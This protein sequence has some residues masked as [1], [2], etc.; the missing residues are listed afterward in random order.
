MLLFNGLFFSIL[1]GYSQNTSSQATASIAIGASYGHALS[2]TFNSYDASGNFYSFYGDATIND[3][4]VGRAQ[5]SQLIP[6]SLSNGLDDRVDSGWSINGSLGYNV[7]TASLPALHIPIMATMGYASFKRSDSFTEPGM[8][9]G[10]TIAP[11][12]FLNDKFIFN[13]SLRWLKG[14]EVDNG[15]EIGQT[16]ISIGVMIRIL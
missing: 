13:A 4:L 8:Q 10:V 15:S 2:L 12:Y 11:K 16:D 7:T 1:Y 14:I 6:S 9:V 5:I 3:K